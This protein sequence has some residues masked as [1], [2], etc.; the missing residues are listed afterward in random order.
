[1]RPVVLYIENGKSL[2]PLQM[3]DGSGNFF[4]KPNGIFAIKRCDPVIVPTDKWKGSPTRHAKRTNAID[5][6]SN[7]SLFRKELDQSQHPQWCWITNDRYVH[8]AIS[9]T[10][11]GSL[12]LRSFYK[13]EIGSTSALYLDG[14]I[15]Q[16]YIPGVSTP[17]PNARSAPLSSSSSPVSKANQCALN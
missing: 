7:S 15:S 17:F 1:M 4:N 11:C 14:H 9:L 16:A 13:N 6:W 10:R 12:I 3:G 5:R 8:F 2:V